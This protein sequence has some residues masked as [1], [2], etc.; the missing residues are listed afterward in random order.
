MFDD[1]FG[2][3]RV[4]PAANARL[5]AWHMALAWRIIARNG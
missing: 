5:S 4:M 1:G 3:A 2:F